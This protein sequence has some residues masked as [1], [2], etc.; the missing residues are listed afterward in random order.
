MV[1]LNPGV[2]LEREL[3]RREVM[4]YGMSTTVQCVVTNDA[5]FVGGGD[6]NSDPNC[7]TIMKFDLQQDGWTTLPQY[8]AKW[9]AMTSLNNRLLLVGGCDVRI[10]K[11][12]N[13]IAMLE[14]AVYVLYPPMKIA[15]HSST[16]VHF[17]NYIIVAGGSRDLEH[18]SSVEV[19]NVQSGSWHFAQSLPRPISQLK[20]TLIGDTLYLMGGWEN[21]NFATKAVYKVDLNKLTSRVMIMPTP[22]EVIEDTP[23][24]C[25]AP[26]NVR[27]SLYA[28]GGHNYGS[29]NSSIYIYQPDIR[30]WVKVGDLPTARWNCTCS[31][32]PSGE[33]LAAGGQTNF[34]GS[35]YC[36]TANFL[37]FK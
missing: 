12:T 14:N 35:F 7:C 27:G 4:P 29:P 22:W 19:M 6:A 15:R 37:L 2:T 5:V 20:S 1:I 16:V 21:P 13:Q 8:I 30:R 26:L 34:L 33:V 3:K 9:F 31:V 32:L 17:I 10:Q 23:L 25:S 28:V 18:L 11:S 24:S 36:S